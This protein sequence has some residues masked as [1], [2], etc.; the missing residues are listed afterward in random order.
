MSSSQQLLLGEGA[1]GGGA[2][3]SNYIEDVFST[4]LYTGTGATQSITNGIDLSGKG[5][6]VWLKQR[7]SIGDTNN[8]LVNTVSGISKNLTSN[9]TD[10]QQTYGLLASVS[11][12]GYVDQ[13]G[14]TSGA[15]V[16]SWTFR[17]Q[18]KFFDIVTY[19]GNGANR[20]ISHNLGSAPGCI[21]IKRTNSSMEWIVWH[22][23]L[24]SAVYTLYL[25]YDQQESATNF[26]RGVT[27]SSTSFS[28]TGGNEV[29][30]SGGTYVAY[31]FAHDAGGFGLTG[32]DNVISCGSFTPDGSGNATVNLGYE[33]QWVLM[34]S[35]TVASTN[36]EIYDV[37]R[38]ASNS[39]GSYLNANTSGAEATTTTYRPMTPTATGFTTSGWWVGAGTMI[40]IA[41]RRGPMKVPTDATKVFAPVASSVSDG[42]QLTTNFPIDMQIFRKRNLGNPTYVVDRLRGV[43]TTTTAISNPQLRTNLANAEEN[44][45]GVAVNWNNTGFAMPT[46]FGNVGDIFWSFARAPNF[47][48]EVCYSG[49]GSA[50]T[51]THNLQA[52]PELM[53]VKN[54][55]VSNW[56]VYSAA[57]GNTKY[58]TLNSTTDTQT[59]TVW[60]NTTPT[61]TVFSIGTTTNVNSSGATYVAY[62]FAT[63]AGVSK[64]GSYTGNGSSQTINCGFTGGARFV[65]IKRT[66]ST[67]DWYVW[68]TA[69]GIV[70]GNDP[71]LSLNTT[72]VEVTTNDTIDTDSTGFVVNQVAATNVNVSSATYIFLAIA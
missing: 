43:G 66:V 72:A 33:P 17:K 18:P 50:T 25:N 7:S 34:K 24:T 16:V 51:V 6:L 67:G 3:A 10:A 39:G 42:E 71:H 54:R 47:M 23:G 61:S 26:F 44:T 68:D 70:A 9:N 52:V 45:T 32:T 35:A 41:I 53:I 36:W 11:S 57:V 38:G 15:T 30:A 4:Y 69:R 21:I 19:T 48:D 13:V 8:Y 22:R 2:A 1:G 60:N 5:G 56:V 64:V 55:G 63:C 37:M 12:T 58:L 59:A 20:T 29:N 28:V 62:L 46:G 65:F 14:W 49:T 27:P 40:Y 31:L